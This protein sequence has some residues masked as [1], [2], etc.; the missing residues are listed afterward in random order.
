MLLLHFHTR[1]NARACI[2]LDSK[3]LCLEDGRG[4][5]HPLSIK[6]QKKKG[7][8]RSFKTF[9]SLIAA[10]KPT[11]SWFLNLGSQPK[12]KKEVPSLKRRRK[13]HLNPFPNKQPVRFD[14][15]DV[16]YGWR[17]DGW[18]IKILM[19][20]RGR[21]LHTRPWQIRGMEKIPDGWKPMKWNSLSPAR[22]SYQIKCGLSSQS[23]TSTG[24]NWFE[25][26]NPESLLYLV[27]PPRL[28]I[29]AVRLWSKA[30][31]W[32]DN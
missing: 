9:P 22:C 14:Q 25:W 11:R 10:G 28:A 7:P 3:S 23:S 30:I 15:I 31:K 21:D 24:P 2:N 12:E 29:F 20:R 6:G 4:Q 1:P 13:Y 5:I 17:G 27:W 26:L 8:N 32:G 19:K 18:D 16:F